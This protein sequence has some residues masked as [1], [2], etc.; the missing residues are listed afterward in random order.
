[1]IYEVCSESEKRLV[2]IE[3]KSEN[4]NSGETDKVTRHDK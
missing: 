1:M 4:E 2:R 3:V